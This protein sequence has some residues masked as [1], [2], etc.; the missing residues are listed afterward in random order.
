MDLTGR[1]SVLLENRE[2]N[3]PLQ[4][5]EEASFEAG[6]IDGKRVVDVYLAI[7]N[8]KT[9][10]WS[11]FLS[12]PKDGTSVDGEESFGVHHLVNAL[13]KLDGETRVALLRVETE[14]AD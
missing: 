8:E 6:L 1:V 12:L 2:M 10:D 9:L 3:E 7:W 4:I 14:P 5:P 11:R 13:E